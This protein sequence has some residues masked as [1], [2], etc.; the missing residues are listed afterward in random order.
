MSDEPAEHWSDDNIEELVSDFSRFSLLTWLF[1][2]NFDKFPIYLMNFREL[3]LF[4]NNWG[5]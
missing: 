2:F 4:K 1:V 3:I 5:T